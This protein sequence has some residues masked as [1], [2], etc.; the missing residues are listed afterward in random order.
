MGDAVTGTA[1]WRVFAVEQAALDYCD[2]T[3]AAI[4][5]GVPV[6]RIPPE[7]VALKL[8]LDAAV[9]AAAGDVRSVPG[10]IVLSVKF[11][12][13]LGF[14]WQGVIVPAGGESRAW[15]LPRIT[16]AGEFAVPCL[17]GF[18]VG[19]PEPGWPQPPS[20]SFPPAATTVAGRGR[21][22]GARR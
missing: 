15:A 22:R 7:F 1:G 3:W 13:I 21:S 17:E 5:A 18:D 10:E 14:D 20:G 2:L 4:V 16:A 6:A 11:V 19:G 8:A 9:R 12:P